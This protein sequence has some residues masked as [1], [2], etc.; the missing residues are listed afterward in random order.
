MGSILAFS[1]NS[2]STELVIDLTCTSDNP[3]AINIH[4]LMKE[5]LSIFISFI[6]FAFFSSQALAELILNFYCPY[7]FSLETDLSE[8]SC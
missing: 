7:T 3:S 2:P 6:S 8:P 5:T 1:L 4:S